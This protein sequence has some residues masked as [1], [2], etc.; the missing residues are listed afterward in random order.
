M[1]RER[2]RERER[3]KKKRKIDTRIDGHTSVLGDRHDISLRKFPKYQLLPIKHWVLEPRCFCHWNFLLELK[4]KVQCK[5]KWSLSTPLK[6][7]YAT[8]AQKKHFPV[9]IRPCGIQNFKHHRNSH[10]MR[11]NTG[12]PA[13]S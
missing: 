8:L 3:E 9:H 1:E 4:L 6:T 7:K 5:E 2:K 11:E 10:F 13:I 12:F